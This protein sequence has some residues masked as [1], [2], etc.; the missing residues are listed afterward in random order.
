[1]LVALMVF[2]FF[3]QQPFDFGLYLLKLFDAFG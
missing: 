1:L 2:S 3:Q